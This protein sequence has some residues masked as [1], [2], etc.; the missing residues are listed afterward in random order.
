MLLNAVALLA[1]GYALIVVL[2][3]VFQARLVYFPEIGRDVATTPRLVGLDYEGVWLDAGGD[4]R[5]HGWYVAH[6]APKGVMLLFHG[7]AGS[8]ALRLDW[9]RMFHDLG[10][11]SFIV[12]YRGYGRSTGSP[13]EAG[14][15]EDAKAAWDHLVAARG[16]A[17][18]DI[19]LVGESLGGAIAA[20]LASRVSPRALVVQS[21]FTSVPDLAAQLYAFLPVRWIS[22]FSYDTAAYLR[23]VKAPVL[24]AHSPHDE[25]VPFSHA[26]RL[27]EHAHAP[28]TFVQ[29]AGGHNEGFLFGRREWVEAL[30]RFLDSA[31]NSAATPGPAGARRDRQ[32]PATK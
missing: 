6:R 17:P 5:L 8:I 26:R 10:Y 11:A 16:W 12:D 13:T 18:G 2:V 23:A 32:S 22:R 19:V 7:N 20:Q 24:I 14:T 4:V 29:L 9:L 27:F 1:I 21:T 28:K 31:A 3:V 15:Y 25:I 30:G